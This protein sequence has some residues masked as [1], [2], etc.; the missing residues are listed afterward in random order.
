MPQWRT[1]TSPLN[2]TVKWRIYFHWLQCLQN[3]GP[4]GDGVGSDV[5]PPHHNCMNTLCHLATLMETCDVALSKIP[6]RAWQMPSLPHIIPLKMICWG[7]GDRVVWATFSD[8]GSQL[9]QFAWGPFQLLWAYVE[10]EENLF[11]A[12]PW[13]MGIMKGLT[14]GSKREAPLHAANGVGEHTCVV[15]WSKK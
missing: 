12:G 4:K 3:C 15:H 11:R 2:S 5:E 10:E 14:I 8:T 7:N 9:L 13:E 6:C 1:T